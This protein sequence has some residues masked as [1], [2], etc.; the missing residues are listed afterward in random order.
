MPIL[1]VGSKIGEIAAAVPDPHRNLMV[2]EPIKY[3]THNG[4]EVSLNSLKKQVD[5]DNKKELLPSGSPK[6]RISGIRGIKKR[7]RL[8]CNSCKPPNCTDPGT[9]GGAVSCFTSIFRD[10]EG[11]VHRSKGKDLKLMRTTL[12]D[13]RI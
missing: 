5:E 9:C 2:S 7:N 8:T 11:V 10:T 12:K 13:S 1:T 6:R 4:I 3:V